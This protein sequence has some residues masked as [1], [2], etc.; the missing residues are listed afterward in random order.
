MFLFSVFEVPRFNSFPIDTLPHGLLAQIR[1]TVALGL[2]IG[3]SSAFL[4]W[5]QLLGGGIIGGLRGVL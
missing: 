4:A 3:G 1:S 2:G 5:E